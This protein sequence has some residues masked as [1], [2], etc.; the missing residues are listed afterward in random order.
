LA[1]EPIDGHFDIGS[2]V[3][4]MIQPRHLSHARKTAYLGTISMPVM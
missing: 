2:A 3:D 1:F 4:E